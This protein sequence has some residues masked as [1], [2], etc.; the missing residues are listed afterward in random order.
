MSGADSA[1][2]CIGLQGNLFD[3]A[4]DADFSRCCI[5]LQGNLFD[6]VSRFENSALANQK[7]RFNPL[8][9]FACLG[10]LLFPLAHLSVQKYNFNA[11]FLSVSFFDFRRAVSD[12]IVFLQFKSAE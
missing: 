9:Q 3:A 8:L 11:I 7:E 12:K 2:C 10:D 1:K 5:A 4:S 6:T